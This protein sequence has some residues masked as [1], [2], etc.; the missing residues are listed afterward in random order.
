MPS[1]TTIFGRDTFALRRDGKRRKA[2]D[3]TDAT[4]G[5]KPRKATEGHGTPSEGIKSLSV[6]RP[7]RPYLHV[8]QVATNYQ[9]DVR[10]VSHDLGDTNKVQLR[11]VEEEPHRGLKARQ[12]RHKQIDDEIPL[13]WFH[14]QISM[15]SLGG[16]MT[17]GVV[18]M[19]GKG[20]E[21]GWQ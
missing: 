2:T 18:I 4:E 11:D 1:A 5:R 3:A 10:Q 21:R 16:G 7:L 17:I 12:V 14:F 9:M 15:M 20:L 6:A 13:K 19:G 8:P